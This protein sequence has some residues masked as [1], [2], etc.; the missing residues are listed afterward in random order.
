MC[1]LVD[2]WNHMDQLD[3]DNDP[4]G[5]AGWNGD[6]CESCN[7]SGYDSG[8]SKCNFD[9]GIVDLLVALGYELPATRKMEDFFMHC[10]DDPEIQDLTLEER[11]V[12]VY[13]NFDFGSDAD[14]LSC[15]SLAEPVGA[16]F[17]NFPRHW[18]W[19]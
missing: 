14:C 19:C 1:D 12:L 18:D 3:F 16:E 11:V 15:Y 10:M 17:K 5:L 6:A 2:N 13:D 7:D 9:E 8:D 4:F